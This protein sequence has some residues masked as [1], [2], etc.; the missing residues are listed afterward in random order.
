MDIKQLIID[1][2]NEKDIEEKIYNEFSLQFEL[3]I[4]LRERLPRWYKVEFERNISHFAFLKSEFYKKE[5]DIVIYTEDKNEKYAIELKQPRNGQVPEQMY[6]FL[7]D[8]AFVEQLK[9]S[10]FDKTFALELTDDKHFWEGNDEGI[11]QYFRGNVPVKDVVYKPTGKGKDEEK[12]VLQR[13][14]TLEWKEIFKNSRY[15]LIEI[16]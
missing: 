5:M 9:N 13:E 2:L 6:H 10:G 3:G 7:T 11:Y 8:I 4:Y 12:I 15:I 16:D 1:F 14:Y